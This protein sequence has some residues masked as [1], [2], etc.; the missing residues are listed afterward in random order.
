[1]IAAY[2]L[3]SFNVLLESAYPDQYSLDYIFISYASHWKIATIL[4]K[5]LEMKINENSASGLRLRHN[6]KQKNQVV[7]I[8]SPNEKFIN[9]TK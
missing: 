9:I 5:H 6:F 7:Y 4:I 8:S 2:I 3:G 1:M